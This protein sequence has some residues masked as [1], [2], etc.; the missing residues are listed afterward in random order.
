MENR[1][2]H[3]RLYAIKNGIHIYSMAKGN[4]QTPEYILNSKIILIYTI[5]VT[6]GQCDINYFFCLPTTLHPSKGF[7][8]SREREKKK[9][10]SIVKNLAY[11]LRSFDHVQI[12]NWKFIRTQ[13][14][15]SV[16]Q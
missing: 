9:Y 3:H 8:T 12:E 2:A 5:S 7:I 13:P 6:V 16:V 10:D 15:L 4:P 14:F 11:V 1:D